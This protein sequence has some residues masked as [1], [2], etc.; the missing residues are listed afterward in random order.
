[1]DLINAREMGHIKTSQVFL[2]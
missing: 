1:M 2:I